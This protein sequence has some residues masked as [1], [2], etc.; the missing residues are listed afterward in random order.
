MNSFEARRILGVD[1]KATTDDIKNAYRRLASKN[2]PDKG[3]DAEEFKKIQAAYDKLSNST[4]RSGTNQ[5]EFG[6]GDSAEVFTEYIDRVVRNAYWRAGET[7]RKQDG[8]WEPSTAKVKVKICPLEAFSGVS[9]NVRVNAGKDKEPFELTIQINA[10]VFN[11]ETVHVQSIDN[12]TYVFV[13]DISPDTE[14]LV[15]W[16]ANEP[17]AGN[18]Y[19]R[20]KLNP[21]TMMEGG[22]AKVICPLDQSEISVRVAAVT[23]AGAKLKIKGKGY[24]KNQSLSARGDIILEVIPDI[25]QLSN[26]SEEEKAKMLTAIISTMEKDS[27][28]AAISEFVKDLQWRDSMQIVES[29]GIN[30]DES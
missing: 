15:N 14:Y 24:W 3:G 5:D 25:K 23:Q 4:L 7:S 30:K 2:H 26:Y 11:Q 17:G 28:V 18:V 6:W 8:H 12:V 19:T 9:K 20:V 13:V 21:I 1:A 27:I 16:N 29:A 10:G 22:W